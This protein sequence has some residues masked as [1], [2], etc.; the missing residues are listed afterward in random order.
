MSQNKDTATFIRLNGK[1]ASKL[2]GSRRLSLTIDKAGVG[3]SLDIQNGTLAITRH[4]LWLLATASNQPL[5]VANRV[6]P[7]MT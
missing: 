6:S 4:L 3:F 2:T 5:A 1:R 7:N